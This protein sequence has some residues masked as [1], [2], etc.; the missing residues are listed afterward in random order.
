MSANRIAKDIGATW[1]AVQYQFGIEHVVARIG[2]HGKMLALVQRAHPRA[3]PTEVAEVGQHEIDVVVLAGERPGVVELRV[4][5]PYE[6]AYFS[7]V[8]RRGAGDDQMLLDLH[9]G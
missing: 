2:E 8:R 3:A 6:G 7:H 4:H 5:D 9:C 1:G